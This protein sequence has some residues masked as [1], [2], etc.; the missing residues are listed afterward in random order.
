MEKQVNEIEFKKYLISFDEKELVTM[1]ED[2]DLTL[3]QKR[4][5]CRIMYASITYATEYYDRNEA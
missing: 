3:A 5:V 1:L 4:R 2:E